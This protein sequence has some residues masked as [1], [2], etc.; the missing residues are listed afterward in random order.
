MEQEKNLERKLGEILCALGDANGT[1]ELIAEG[2]YAEYEN[3][4]AASAIRLVTTHIRNDIYNVLSDLL[5]HIKD[6]C[7]EKENG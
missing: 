2:I 5:Y 1:L 4:K 7:I 3:D 6:Y